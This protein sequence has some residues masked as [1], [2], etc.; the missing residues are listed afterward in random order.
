VSANRQL[1]ADAVVPVSVS[2]Q[3]VARQE[4]VCRA[5]HRVVNGEPSRKV[6]PTLSKSH[7]L[8]SYLRRLVNGSPTVSREISVTNR[9][10]RHTGGTQ[11]ANYFLLQ[12]SEA[13]GDKTA[14]RF[15]PPKGEDILIRKHGPPESR[16]RNLHDELFAR[17]SLAARMG[18]SGPG[19]GSFRAFRGDT[20]RYPDARVF[21]IGRRNLRRQDV[22]DKS[23]GW[24]DV[25]QSPFAEKPGNVPS[26]GF[27]G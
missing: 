1:S 4:S 21:T 23:G 10:I 27:L 6:A 8:G 5:T 3:A 19:N 15:Q 18:K 13:P 26:L 20:R 9:H 17:A 12:F 11:E 22:E 25:F 24:P 7:H 2:L 14:V 16:R